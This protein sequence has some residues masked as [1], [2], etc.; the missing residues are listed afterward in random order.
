[1]N[2]ETISR[3]LNGLPEEMI[4]EAIQ[5]V[6]KRRP[7]WLRLA[8]CAAV[9]ALVIAG[10][11]LWPS[12]GGI[13]TAPGIL[14]I[15]VQAEDRTSESGFTIIQLEEGI[16]APENRS[17]ALVMNRSPGLPVS[18]SVESE[19]YPAED[20][21]FNITVDHGAYINWKNKNNNNS[22]SIE[23]LP[24]EFTSSNHVQIYWNI[25]SLDYPIN[26]W[27]ENEDYDQI[28]TD[29]VIYCEDHIIGYAVLRFDRKYSEENVPLLS[30]F[31]TLVESVTFPKVNGQFQPVTKEYVQECISEV[32]SK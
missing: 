6:R 27:Y 21:T 1:M 18:L 10:G 23:Y 28:Y 11:V 14:T 8:A 20:I 2:G 29:I 15:T 12:G 19:D 30:Y 32:H 22:Y 16:S 17:W 25:L 3:A 5:P 24:P 7:L 13:Q 4:A 31:S 26:D 9:L